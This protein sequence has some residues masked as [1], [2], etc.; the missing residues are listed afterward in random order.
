M[1]IEREALPPFFDPGI[2]P[3]RKAISQ[4]PVE[5]PGYIDKVAHADTP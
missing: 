2:H 3:K 1:V 5:S 4:L